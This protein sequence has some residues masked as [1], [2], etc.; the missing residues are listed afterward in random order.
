[1]K[2][3]E[4]KKKKTYENNVS[5]RTIMKIMKKLFISSDFWNSWVYHQSFKNYS[6]P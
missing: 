6:Y 1:M 5:L 2:F 3:E 4:V